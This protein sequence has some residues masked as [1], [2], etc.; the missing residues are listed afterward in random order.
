MRNPDPELSPLAWE[1]MDALFYAVFDASGS[2]NAAESVYEGVL[3]KV[4]AIAPMP[5]A[6]PSVATKTGIPCDYRWVEH[7]GWLA[8]Y[9]VEE[10]GGVLVDRVLWGRSEWTRTL[11]LGETQ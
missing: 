2:P 3:K 8:F 5:L 6:A 10:N 11:G 9:H 1:D 7:K 4:E